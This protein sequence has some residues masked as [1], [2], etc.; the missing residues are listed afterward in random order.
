VQ[1]GCKPHHIGDGGIAAAGQPTADD[2]LKQ[3]V[4]KANLA[5]RKRLLIQS[6]L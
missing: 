6:S 4:P 3:V 5:I 1:R 2:V